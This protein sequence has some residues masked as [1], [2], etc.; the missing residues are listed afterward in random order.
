MFLSL[1]IPVRQINT[2]SLQSVSQNGSNTKLVIY[3]VA[4]Q[5]PDTEFTVEVL[6][7]TVIS[8]SPINNVSDFHEIVVSGWSPGTTYF[9][10]LV[11][12]TGRQSAWSNSIT[13]QSTL[14]S[15]L[16]Y[17][18]AGWSGSFTVPANAARMEVLV[19]G[20]G[21]YGGNPALEQNLPQPYY[22]W[23]GGGGGGGGFAMKNNVSVSPGEVFGYFVGHSAN[24]IS[25]RQTY[26]FKGVSYNQTNWIRAGGGYAS[27]EMPNP[28]FGPA[29]T[30]GPDPIEATGVF[31][32]LTNSGVGQ[33]GSSA[34]GAGLIIEPPIEINGKGGNG[35]LS[36]AAFAGI[37][38]ASTGGIGSTDPN[39][40][41]TPATGYGCGGGGG[42]VSANLYRASLGSA[43]TSGYIKVDFYT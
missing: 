15:T 31:L 33:S 32:G 22:G 25:S 21:G 42:C 17:T 10:R 4:S 30:Y 12:S 1:L 27:S 24:S 37:G 23:G 34:T 26:I 9:V 38:P 14:I 39:V 41:A 28:H 19:I 3:T 16:T 11:D 29:G 43:G 13:S 40:N 8:G 2:P 35:G 5:N 36:G 7:Q 18:N 20:A 6:G